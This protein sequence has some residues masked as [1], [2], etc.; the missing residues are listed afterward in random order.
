[1]LPC[2]H[3]SDFLCQHQVPKRLEDLRHM[4]RAAH[5]RHMHPAAHPGH[6]NMVPGL[7]SPPTTRR[8]A[9]TKARLSA[10]QHTT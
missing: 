2:D 7:L 9:S 5:L 4:H 6:I 8:S 1:M 3:V 10:S